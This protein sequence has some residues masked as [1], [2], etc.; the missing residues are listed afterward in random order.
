MLVDHLAFHYL[1]LFVTFDYVL[2]AVF[3]CFL[4]DV[5]V[6]VYAKAV[7]LMDTYFIIAMHY[8]LELYYIYFIN[9]GFIRV[10]SE[11]EMASVIA[12]VAIFITA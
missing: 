3:D 6:L 5:E 10:A 8:V 4:P 9:H 2:A 1:G 7:C 12:V 11:V